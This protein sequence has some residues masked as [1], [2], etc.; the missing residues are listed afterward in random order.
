MNLIN[1]FII[2]LI[3]YVCYKIVVF[4]YKDTKETFTVTEK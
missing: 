1:L 3:L 4:N 2:I